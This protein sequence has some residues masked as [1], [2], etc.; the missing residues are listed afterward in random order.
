MLR[1]DRYIINLEF[2]FLLWRLPSQFLLLNP[3]P[4][5]LFRTWLVS[6]SIQH[7]GL[8]LEKWVFHGRPDLRNNPDVLLALSR[9]DFGQFVRFIL[10]GR[11]L[12][13]LSLLFWILCGSLWA[14]IV[15]ILL[16]SLPFDVVLLQ[17][18]RFVTLSP[19]L[20]SFLRSLRRCDWVS[21]FWQRRPFRV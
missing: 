8:R 1:T 19:G 3:C 16:W 6:V 9:L 14:D 5:N 11:S 7:F 17:H 10:L 13:G 12:L 20:K 2:S 4:C 15:E 18:D 21:A